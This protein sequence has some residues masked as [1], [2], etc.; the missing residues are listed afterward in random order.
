MWL[1]SDSW[2]RFGV[3]FDEQALQALGLATAQNR[4]APWRAAGVAGWPGA[5]AGAA[6][7]LGTRYRWIGLRGGPQKDYVALQRS[8]PIAIWHIA[9]NGSLNQDPGAD[10][11]N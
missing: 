11:L 2:V 7:Y 9:I 1:L 5:V 10:Y 6:T 8:I 3:P 4:S